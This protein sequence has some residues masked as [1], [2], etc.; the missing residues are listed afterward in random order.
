MCILHNSHDLQA[1]RRHCSDNRH[2]PVVELTTWAREQLKN[3]NTVHHRIH[4][5][6]GKL[7]YATRIPDPEMPPPSLD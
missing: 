4:K 3:T 2:D 1:I 6:K 7:K 5:Y